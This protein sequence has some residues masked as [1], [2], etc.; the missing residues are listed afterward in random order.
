MRRN[1]NILSTMLLASEWLETAQGSGVT[2]DCASF[3]EVVPATDDVVLDKQINELSNQEAVVVFTSASAVEAVCAQ[4]GFSANNWKI[5]CIEKA[6][7]KAVSKYFNSLQIAGTGMNAEELAGKIMAGNDVKEVVFFCGDKRMDTL[8]TTL[9]NKG[10]ITREIVVY[11]TV[12]RPQF[13]EKEYNGYLFYSPSGVSSFFSMNEVPEAAVLFAIGNTTAQALQLE[14][15]NEII[16]SEQPS[17]EILLQT[18]VNHFTT[19][20]Q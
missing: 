10:I 16:V 3:I 1:T 15:S 20:N 14:C 17:K 5:Y 7:L 18:A 9:L 19:I 6:T 12:E 2:V 4:P 8:P 11:N 13:V